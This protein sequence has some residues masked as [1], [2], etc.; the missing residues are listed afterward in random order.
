M[1]INRILLSIFL[2]SSIAFTGCKKDW[3]DVNK[4]PETTASADP[5]LLLYGAQTE[6]STNRTTEIG[7]SGSMWSQMWASGASAGV[8]RNPE[9]YIFSIFTTGNTWRSHYVNSQKNLKFAIELAEN[10]EVGTPNPRVAAQCKIMSSLIFYTTTILWGDVPYTQAIDENV[11]NPRFDS[12]EDI[13]N[14]LI[15]DLDE[16]IAQID[17][18]ELDPDSPAAADDF[19]YGGD[20]A[21]WKAFARSLKFRILLLMVDADPS[22][23]AEITTMLAEG[24]M[25]A[26]NNDNV[27]FGYYNESGHQNPNWN[28]LNTFAG[29]QNFFYFASVTTVETMKKYNDPRLPVYFDLGTDTTGYKGVYPGDVRD[30]EKDS[31]ISLNV[32]TPDAP[33][34]VYT[35]TE[36]LFLEAEA[37]FRFGSVAT[38]DAKMRAAITNSMQY[39]GVSQTDIDAYLLAI[40]NLATQTPAAGLQLIAEQSWISYIDK[41]IEA[42]TMWRRLEFPALNL[43]TGAALGDFVRRL[44]YP[45]DELSANPNAPSVVQGDVKMWFDL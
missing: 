19:Y 43:P 18:A 16:A 41:P 4:D 3:L 12:Q 40:P 13:L 27:E 6:Y 21:Q 38:A 32:V 10:P 30:L 36:Q 20:M 34:R 22:K 11:D 7:L 2:I 39:W 45:P 42:W 23:Q 33:E 28:V 26:S 44:P 14:G 5:E 8:F 29:G 31:K 9:R 25:I 15:A 24:G 1:K 35:Y 17:A 37:E